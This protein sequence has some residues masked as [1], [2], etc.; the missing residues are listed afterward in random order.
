MASWRIG[1]DVPFPPFAV[2][3]GGEPRGMIVELVG[4]AAARAGIGVEWRPMRLEDT[5]PALQAG[6][7]DALAFKGVTP[8]RHASMDFSRPLVVSGAAVFRRPQLQPS[9]DPRSFAG[10]RA[11]TSRKGPFAALLANDYPELRPVMVES[12]EQAFERMLADQADIAILNF[13]AGLS[14]A[15]SLYPGRLSLP[16]APFAPLSVALAVAKGRE[17]AALAAFNIA[18][19]ATE[20]DGSAARI[21]DRWLAG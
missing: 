16:R 4:A 14:I 21:V 18:L 1:F 3:E 8:E 19:E 9:D 10:L 6:E 7:V 15:H 2:V 5:E 12:H 20:A 13:H 17:A 11:A